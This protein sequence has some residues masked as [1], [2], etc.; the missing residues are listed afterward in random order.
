MAR[1][2][3]FLCDGIN[4]VPMECKFYFTVQWMNQ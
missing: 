2:T 4:H 1:V 3:C